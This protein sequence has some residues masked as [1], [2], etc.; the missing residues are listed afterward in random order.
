MKTK[1]TRARNRYRRSAAL[2]ALCLTGVAARAAAPENWYA[3]ATYD[4]SNVSVDR[5]IGWQLSAEESGLSLFGGLRVSK[6]FAADFALEHVSD[7]RWGEAFAQVPDVPDA[8]WA[9]TSFDTTSLQASAVGIVPFGRYWELFGRAGLAYS[10]F[11]GTQRTGGLLSGATRSRHVSETDAGY[12]IGLGI[13]LT[14]AHGWHLSFEMQ[15][16]DID[17]DF[18]GVR[19][20]TTIDSWKFGL[21]RRFG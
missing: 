8:F 3:G 19:S 16:I 20:Q 13:G 12:L 6:H 4:V 21:A 18:L 14:V 1:S 7:L 15:S 10:E 11:D 5:G 17:A 9:D 2:L